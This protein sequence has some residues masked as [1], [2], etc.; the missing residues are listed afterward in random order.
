MMRK[1]KNLFENVLISI[2]LTMI[3][4][5]LLMACSNHSTE[6]FPKDVERSDYLDLKSCWKIE[7]DIVAFVVASKEVS[8]ERMRL[9]FI[10]PICDVTVAGYPPGLGF[11]EYINALPIREDGGI[12]KGYFERDFAETRSNHFDFPRDASPIFLFR[13]ELEKGENCDRCFDIKRVKKFVASKYDFGEIKEKSPTERWRIFKDWLM[14]KS[15][16]NDSR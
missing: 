12:A 16:V 11:V 5:A 10:S 3:P 1:R 13:G 4:Y 15:A 8:G 9:F 14:P 6:G 2:I 7:G